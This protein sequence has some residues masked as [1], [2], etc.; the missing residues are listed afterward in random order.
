MT[1]HLHPKRESYPLINTDDEFVAVF[2]SHLTIPATPYLYVKALTAAEIRLDRSKS[3]DDRIGYEVLDYTAGGTDTITITVNGG[4][5]TVLT[6]GTDFDAVV[7]NEET[8]LQIAAAIN[9]AAIDLIATADGTKVYIAG[10][11]NTGVTHISLASG[12]PLAWTPDTLAYHGTVI[13]LVTQQ[14]TEI[15]IYGR[16]PLDVVAFL[17]IFKGKVSLDLRSPVECRTY[18]RQPATLSGNTGHPGGW[19]T[20]P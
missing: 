2:R 10:V 12:D 15:S 11:A 16:D 5:S 6:E 13:S 18:L 1:D 8:A 4:G 7:S 14:T 20:T 3:L 19:P 9:T 17:K